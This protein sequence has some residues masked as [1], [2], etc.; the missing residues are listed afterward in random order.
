MSY[1]VV[2]LIDLQD[3]MV[4]SMKL[5]IFYLLVRL[6]GECF[7]DRIPMSAINHV[8]T[9]ICLFSQGVLIATCGQR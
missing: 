4:L 9:E 2:I 6:S 7:E 1:N 3:K 5:T 8:Y